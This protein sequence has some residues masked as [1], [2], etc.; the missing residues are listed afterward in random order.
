MRLSQSNQSLP[1]TRPLSVTGEREHVPS[2]RKAAMRQ[3]GRRSA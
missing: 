3:L 1:V 2:L